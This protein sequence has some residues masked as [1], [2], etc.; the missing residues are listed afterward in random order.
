MWMDD[1]KIYSQEKEGFG[2]AA[3][4]TEERALKYLDLVRNEFRQRVELKQQV[5]NVYLFGLAALTAFVIQGYKDHH[6]YI[7][8]LW[9]IPFFSLAAAAFF[10][11]HMIVTTSLSTYIKEELEPKLVA[12]Y[13]DI[14]FWDR[15]CAMRHL[16]GLFRVLNAIEL[17]IICGPVAALLIFHWWLEPHVGELWLGKGPEFLLTVYAAICF[18]LDLWL[19]VKIGRQSQRVFGPRQPC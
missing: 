1:L 7:H 18:V 6:Q 10:A 9:L 14:P 17:T 5:L 15:A 3:S 16:P 8:A 13:V 12:D 4:A 19:V 11:D 2:M